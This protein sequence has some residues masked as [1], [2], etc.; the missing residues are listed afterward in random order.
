MPYL[1]WQ[2]LPVRTDLPRLAY[3]CSTSGRFLI[4]YLHP[5]LH[6]LAT[7]SSHFA[8]PVRVLFPSQT[9]PHVATAIARSALCDRPSLSLGRS[10]GTVGGIR[11]HFTFVC[12]VVIINPNGDAS[13]TRLDVVPMSKH[14]NMALS[15]HGC[16]GSLRRHV[17]EYLGPWIIVVSG[18]MDHSG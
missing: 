6:R 16:I 18:H 13:P 10:V 4:G 3:K 7:Q 9:G 2:D 17:H 11:S 14:I 8:R 5:C 15:V 1:Y 12:K